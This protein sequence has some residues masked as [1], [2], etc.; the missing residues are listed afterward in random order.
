M[1]LENIASRCSNGLFVFFIP[2]RRD[3]LNKSIPFSFS[4][5]PG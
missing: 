3:L 2:T 4:A 1:Y 5:M